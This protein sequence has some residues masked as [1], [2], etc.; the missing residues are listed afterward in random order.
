MRIISKTLLTEKVREM[1][2]NAAYDLPTDV[3]TALQRAREKEISPVG[4]DIL[5]KILQNIEIC[6]SELRPLCQDTGTSV[7]FIRKGRD[8]ALDDGLIADAVNEGV[9]IGYEE[10]YLRKSIVRHPLDRVNT[11]TN[12]P[13]II[14]LEE[15]TGDEFTIFMMPKGAGCENMSRLIM[16]A[17]SQGEEG[18]KTFVLETVQKAWANPCPPV[19]VGIG[20]GGN[21]ETAA[22]LAKKALLLQ[23]DETNNDPILARLEK[24]LLEKINCLGIG[25]QGFG[26]S[27]TAL[28]VKILAAP[29]HIASLPVAVNMECHAHRH[30]K[31]NL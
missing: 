9:R 17:P 19:V 26:G 30:K 23:L 29:C 24:E 18:I 13:A 11:K 16:L 6:S 3:K 15:V 7:F 5:D 21:F 27:I 20:I 31:V 1:C 2:I 12:T 14:H 28:A 4:R 25:P 10:G 22:L 8:A